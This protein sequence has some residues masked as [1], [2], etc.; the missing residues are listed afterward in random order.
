MCAEEPADQRITGQ[1]R[2]Q[3]E[4]PRVEKFAGHLVQFRRRLHELQ[5]DPA[6]RHA[7]CAEHNRQA[8]GQQQALQQNLPQRRAIATPG[9]LSREP[10]GAH[11]QKAH[12]PGQ[13]G[14]Q[15]GPDRDGTELMGMGQVTDD[16]AVDQRH[17]R[18]GNVRENHRRRQRPDPTMGRTV[19]PVGNQVGH[20]GSLG[21][22]AL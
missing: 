5:R 12:G 9:G 17:Q 20:A 11:A 10:G 19:A 14:V 4:Q 7:H 2:R 15:A 18:Y 22:R 8:H 6:Q 3:T 13:K 16:G 21:E 1:C